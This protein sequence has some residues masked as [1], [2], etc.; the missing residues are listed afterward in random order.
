MCNLQF[1]F[2]QQQG[3]Q[4]SFKKGI[5]IVAPDSLYSINFR[6][7]VQTRA[8]Y[9]TQ[10]ESDLSASLIDARVRRMRLRM[11]GFMSDPKLT[12]KIQLAF[13]RGDMDFSAKEGSSVNNSPNIIRDAAIYYEPIEGLE[14]V[15]GQ[16]KLPGNRQ[17]VVSSGEQQFMDRSIVN[18]T[19]NIDRDFGIQAHYTKNFQK[20]GFAIKGAISTGEGRNVSSTDGGLAYTG[21]IELLPFGAFTNKGD[22]F[23]GDLEHEQKPKLSIAGGIS[24]ND[25]TKRTAG[26]LGSDLYEA[27]SMDTY[28]F[29]A[30]F[31]YKG[32]AVYGEYMM[33]DVIGS[34]IT[35]SGSNTRYA[36]EGNGSLIQLSYCTK[37]KWEI[38]GR[39][40]QIMP[41]DKI[42]H[43]Q[44]MEEVYTFG[45]TKYLRA[46]RVK[47]QSNLNYHTDTDMI[48]NTNSNY[49]SVG[50]QIELGI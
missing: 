4:I 23:E 24:H 31:K 19:F 12:Y 2:T 37:K 32:F 41:F 21:R 11:E 35:T 27:R 48:G 10:S 5:Q 18:A 33:R 36:F 3:H 25:R 22:Y 6:F 44:K 9:Y 40:A 29:D 8:W 45:V 14:F 34:P 17:R 47:L 28:I 26:Q 30:V 39:Y 42:Q 13:S 20:F 50:F 38:A 1:G 46:H 43:V 7:R 15:F 49:Y 16:T